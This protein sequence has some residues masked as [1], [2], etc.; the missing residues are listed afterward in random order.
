MAKSKPKEPVHEKLM[1]SKEE[2]SYRLLFDFA[3]WLE[4]GL[5]KAG[6]GGATELLR[7]FLKERKECT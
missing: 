7:K 2:E 3:Y 1:I 6:C 4:N 5:G